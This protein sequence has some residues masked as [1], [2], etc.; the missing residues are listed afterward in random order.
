MGESSIDCVLGVNREDRLLQRATTRLDT[1]NDHAPWTLLAKYFAG[2]CSPTEEREVEEWIDEDPSRKELLKQLYSIWKTAGAS[3]SSP[4]EDRLDMESEWQELRAQM[5]PD[6]QP[7]STDDRPAREA[8]SERLTSRP[9]SQKSLLN[10]ESVGAAMVVLLLV[11]GAL[12]VQHLQ[13]SLGES[14]GETNYREVVTERGERASLQLSDGTSVKLNVSSTLRVS[15]EFNSNQ[16]VVHL[17][18]G[19]YFDVATDSTRPFIVQTEDASVDVHGTSFDVRAYP[20]GERRVQVAVEEGSV[21]L[22]PQQDDDVQQGAELGAGEVGWLAGQEKAVMIETADVETYL[23]W[24]EGRL[25]FED[26][27]LSEVAVRLER[28]YNLDVNV[29]DDSLRSLRLTAN[30][31]SHSVRNILDVISAS[32][33]IR[34][35]VNE[36]TVLLMS[37]DRAD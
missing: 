36:N 30:L 8:R 3:T 7:S 13:G 24:T 2:E 19:A 11:G 22:R 37:A 10:R 18:G 32:L 16:R 34:Y 17:T 31:K 15:D 1:V 21:S 26:T 27:P 20:D 23:G 5:P 35:Q 14:N 6:D 12:L 29:R 4:S 9:F 28:W 33:G 25:V